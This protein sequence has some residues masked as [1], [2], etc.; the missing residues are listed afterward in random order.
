MS[1]GCGVIV[2]VIVRSVGAHTHTHAHTDYQ[3]SVID[4]DSVLEVDDGWML[5]GVRRHSMPNLRIVTASMP[6]DSNY[7]TF[8]KAGQ[9]NCM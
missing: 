5:S 1:D 3:S 4:C 8:L 2:S 9:C 6:A 7:S